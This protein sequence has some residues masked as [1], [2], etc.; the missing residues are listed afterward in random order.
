[1][2]IWDTQ[3]D[4]WSGITEKCLGRVMYLG[5]MSIWVIFKKDHK[6]R[7]VGSEDKRIKK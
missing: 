2:E 4:R 7:N 3:L 1:M 5:V 6:V